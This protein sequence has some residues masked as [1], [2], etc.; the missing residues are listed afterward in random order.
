MYKLEYLPIALQDIVEIVNYIS[1]TLKNQESASNLA[2]SFIEK[3]ESLLKFPYKNPVCQLIRPLKY[4]YRKILVENYI[5]FYRVDEEKKL[6]TIARV[7]YA[8]RDFS[9]LLI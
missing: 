1:H 3:A 7:I 2:E 6:V 4:E 9:N 8:K 5:M